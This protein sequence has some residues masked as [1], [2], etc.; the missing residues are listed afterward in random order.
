MGNRLQVGEAL[1]SGPG[2]D[3][4]FWDSLFVDSL[5]LC[6]KIKVLKITPKQLLVKLGLKDLLPPLWENYKFGSL[7]KLHRDILGCRKLRG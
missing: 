6:C 1:E 3:V 4:K 5:I 7:R 2:T